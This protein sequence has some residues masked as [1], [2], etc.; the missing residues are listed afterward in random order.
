MRY[1]TISKSI[2]VKAALEGEEAAVEVKIIC[3]GTILVNSAQES[4]LGADFVEVA[5]HDGVRIWETTKPVR[6]TA[7]LS[8]DHYHRPTGVEVTSIRALEKLWRVL[9]SGFRLKEPNLSGYWK[10]QSSAADRLH[11]GGA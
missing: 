9:E 3:D 11:P 4:D 10:L 2:T 1:S 7:L 8:V 6:L 5:H